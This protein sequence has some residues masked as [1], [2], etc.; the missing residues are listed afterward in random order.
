MLLQERFSERNEGIEVPKNSRRVFFRPLSLGSKKV[1]KEGCV[2]LFE[3][4]LAIIGRRE[5]PS[6]SCEH[7]FFF[8]P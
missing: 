5:L 3:G 6:F 4:I 7:C 8:K 1:G 2:P